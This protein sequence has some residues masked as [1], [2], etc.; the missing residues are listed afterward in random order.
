VQGKGV[1]ENALACAGHDHDSIYLQTQ[2]EGSMNTWTIFLASDPASQCD[3]ASPQA[4][5]IISRSRFADGSYLL[6]DKTVILLI[7]LLVLRVPSSPQSV[8]RWTAARPAQ[9]S[10][11]PAEISTPES[12]E[13][14]K[15]APRGRVR[16]SQARRR[17]RAPRS[18]INRHAHQGELEELTEI[19]AM[20][21]SSASR[22][23]AAEPR[24][25]CR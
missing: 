3:D 4:M 19:L 16:S 8:Y 23:A 20:T 13:Y 15:I 9:A 11:L 25:G 10:N 21:R 5:E 1:V 22:R 24:G 12:V 2:M 7:G 18:Y 6:V 14:S 17:D